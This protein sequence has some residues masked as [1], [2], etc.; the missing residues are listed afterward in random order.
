[1]LPKMESKSFRNVFPIA[2]ADFLFHL[3]VDWG[4]TPAVRGFVQ[5]TRWRWAQVV[6]EKPPSLQGDVWCVV[7][8]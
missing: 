3:L 8:G 2:A 5:M 4:S 6:R 1:M 7:A